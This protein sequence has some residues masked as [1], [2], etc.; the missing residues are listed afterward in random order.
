MLIMITHVV[1]GNGH[2]VNV[3]VECCA[4]A[5]IQQWV[6]FRIT[7]LNYGTQ[8]VILKIT[9]MKEKKALYEI[10]VP[11]MRNDGRP[12]RL[13][14]HKV[15]DEK[16]RNIS[17][18]LTIMSPV[19]GQWLFKNELFQE[20]MIPVRII[21]TRTEMDKIIN[22][23]LKYYDQLAI[24]AYKIS[25]EVLMRYRVP[26]PSKGILRKYDPQ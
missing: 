21:A 16:I 13:R 10:L 4:P 26:E 1:L 2:V 22:M 17:N 24:L 6:V 5:I 25:D 9:G 14:F 11:T 3:F 7:Q 8:R 12:I 15:W 23:T 19:K 18:G 20:R